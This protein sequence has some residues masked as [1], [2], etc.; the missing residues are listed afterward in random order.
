MLT[1]Y[2]NKT[3]FTVKYVCAICLWWIVKHTD[4]HTKVKQYTPSF[5]L[6]R[7]GVIKA[8][9]G[10]IKY[11]FT[12]DDNSILIVSLDKTYFTRQKQGSIKLLL[13]SKPVNGVHDM[14][15]RQSKYHKVWYLS[16]CKFLFWFSHLSKPVHMMLGSLSL[17]LLQ[18]SSLTSC[19]AVAVS[20]RTGT[21]R[22]ELKLG[23]SY[24]ARTGTY[25]IELKLS[26]SNS[27]KKLQSSAKYKSRSG[28]IWKRDRQNSAKVQ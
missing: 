11:L 19:V 9:F 23:T 28:V 14:P 3:M 20:A 12:V 24:S 25:R 2:F 4:T 16:L 26:T 13:S 6:L 1:C 7:S 18:M 17:R 5:L 27:D 8:F 22:T 15:L 21:Y 10:I